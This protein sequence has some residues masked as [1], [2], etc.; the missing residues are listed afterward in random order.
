MI[1]YLQLTAWKVSKYGVSRL[2]FL[3]L[4][5]EMEIYFENLRIRTGYEKIQ[6]KKNSLF[7]YFSGSVTI[8]G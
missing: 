3:E 4:G 1:A 8:Y 5:L 6:T 2:H 7:G